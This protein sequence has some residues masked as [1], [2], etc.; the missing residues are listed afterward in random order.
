MKHRPETA[1]AAAAAHHHSPAAPY[2]QPGLRRRLAA[3]R[4]GMQAAMRALRAKNTSN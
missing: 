4:A 2:S 3:L 1:N